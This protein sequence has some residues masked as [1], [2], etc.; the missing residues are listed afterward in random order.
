MRSASSLGSFLWTI[1][2][3]KTR[4]ADKI[5]KDPMTSNLFEMDGRRW[6][7]VLYIDDPT[8]KLYL[9]LRSAVSSIRVAIR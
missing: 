3:F 8:C 1:D 5:K 6:R 7:L 2:S 9:Q 4:A